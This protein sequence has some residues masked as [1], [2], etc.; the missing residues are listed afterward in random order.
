MTF[1]SVPCGIS[2]LRFEVSVLVFRYVVCATLC[3]AISIHFIAFSVRKSHEPKEQTAKGTQ[4]N[5]TEPEEHKENDNNNAI[6]YMLCTWFCTYVNVYGV[7]L[8]AASVFPSS[9]IGIL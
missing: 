5:Y 3:G 9:Y 8:Y 7:L 1:Y 4:I 6:G 2:T